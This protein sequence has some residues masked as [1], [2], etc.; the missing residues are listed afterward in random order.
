MEVYRRIVERVR[1]ALWAHHRRLLPERQF[2]RILAYV[3]NNKYEYQIRF[4]RMSVVGSEWDGRVE[5]VTTPA[6]HVREVRVNP[7]VSDLPAHRQKQ[8]ILSA[9]SKACREGRRLMAEA[10]MR[11]YKQ[12]L[13]D[14]NPIVM[15]IRDNPEFFTVPKESV[16][17]LG[18]TLAAGGSKQIPRHRTIPAGRAREPKEVV[19]SHHRVEDLWR[20]SEV[21]R[22]W[23]RTLEGKAYLAR[24][25]P[26]DRPPGAPGAKK[27]A[28][29]LSLPVPYMTMDETRLRRRNWMA[30]LDNKHVAETLWTRAQVSDREKELRRQ[31][32]SGEAWHRPVR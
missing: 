14:I 25:S 3:Y 1:G 32:E 17:T 31:Q 30:F 22:H 7:R 28:P 8:L 24:Y 20:S 26:Q 27:R 5:V 6:G 21:G 13:K 18:G 19:Q 12:F 11:V 9:Y 15:G 23:A 4:D 29:P 16:A 2:H 10:E